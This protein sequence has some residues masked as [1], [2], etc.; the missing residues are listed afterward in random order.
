MSENQDQDPEKKEA[1]CGKVEK[2]RPSRKRCPAGKGG[3]RDQEKKKGK[4]PEKRRT[5]KR[6]FRS[7][8]CRGPACERE[9]TEK[10][11]PAH[12]QDVIVQRPRGQSQPEEN[13]EEK[14]MDFFKTGPALRGDKKGQKPGDQKGADDSSGVED[15][16]QRVIGIKE[17]KLLERAQGC[18][19]KTEK[20][21]T[22]PGDKPS[23][24]E[25]HENKVREKGCGDFHQAIRDPEINDGIDGHDACAVHEAVHVYQII[26]YN[27]IVVLGE[28]REE[29][30]H[31]TPG[32]RVDNEG[33]FSVA[34]PCEVMISAVNGLK[35]KEEKKEQCEHQDKAVAAEPG[36]GFLRFFPVSEQEKEQGADGENQESSRSDRAVI[37]EERDDSCD[38]AQQKV[39]RKEGGQPFNASRSTGPAPEESRRGVPEQADEKVK[40]ADPKPPQGM[41]S[42]KHVGVQK[43]AAFVKRKKSEVGSVKG[44]R[45]QKGKKD[46]E[47]QPR[48]PGK[49]GTQPWRHQT[50]SLALKVPMVKS[51]LRFHLSGL[52][53]SAFKDGDLPADLWER[54]CRSGRK[55]NPLSQRKKAKSQVPREKLKKKVY[56]RELAM[57]QIELVRLQEWIREKKLKVVVLF[58]GRDAAGKGGVLKRI[59]EKTNPRVCRVAALGTPTEREKTQWYFQRYVS[60]LPAGGE[61]VLFDRSWYNRAGVERVM[62]F[63]SEEEY[64]EFLRTCP[65]FERML[66]R[67]G[68]ILVKYWF[69]VSDE[70]QEE[71]FQDRIQDPRKRWK[72]SEMDLQARARWVDYSRAKDR[73]FAVTDTRDAPWYVVNADDKKRARLNCIRH[74]LNQIPYHRVGHKKIRIP[75]RQ[76]DKGYRRPPLGEQHF[77]PEVY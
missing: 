9:N 6:G 45:I 21:E 50:K 52:Q 77:I 23:V 69:S 76:K 22:R 1:G 14:D 66:I 70:V 38:A 24:C 54:S 28:K 30:A 3:S 74:L 7:D 40:E 32:N 72:L 41:R 61:M 20:N 68:I 39:S 75:P 4:E 65:E 44:G 33:I 43:E 36:A 48:N 18:R 25:L 58:E 73:M 59:T 64:R 51:P 42:H 56:E 47:S 29:K 67:S 5:E 13:K 34:M 63:C 11:N 31:G 46:V 19:G 10:Q 15:Q 53:A 27:F 35:K 57:L 8:G 2:E 49:S 26:E 62:G 16:E 17:Q 71:R 60:M 55:A 37:H 12:G